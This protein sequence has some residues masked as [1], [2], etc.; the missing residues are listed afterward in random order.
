MGNQKN[1]RLNRTFR[2]WL[3]FESPF[4]SSACPR[5]VL[6]LSVYVPFSVFCVFWDVFVLPLVYPELA[7]ESAQNPTDV[8]AIIFFPQRA[9]GRTLE[10]VQ[11]GYLWSTPNPLFKSWNCGPQ[12]V[13]HQSFIRPSVKTST[14]SKR[15]W[16]VSSRPF[17]FPIFLESYYD[18]FCI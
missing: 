5:F 4:L 12:Y 16:A 10:G 3:P 11:K 18:D 8:L 13:C 15:H 2:R 9:V 14:V 17:K 1:I 6:S 7:L